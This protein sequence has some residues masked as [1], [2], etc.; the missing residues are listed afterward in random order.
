VDGYAVYLLFSGEAP[1]GAGEVV[2]LPRALVDAAAEQT[3]D[4][5]GAKK[6]AQA[7]TSAIV[8]GEPLPSVERLVDFAGRVAEAAAQTGASAILWAPAERLLSPAMLRQALADEDLLRVAVN[9]RLFHVED[10][11][12]GETVMDTVGLAALGLPDG[13]CHFFELDRGEVAT[14][15][16]ELAR[17]L[18]DEGAVIAEGDTVPGP[19]DETWICH[20][21]EALVD[22]AREVIDLEPPAP[23][24]ARRT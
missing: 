20:L 21:E 3:R 5:P 10:G 9:V 17:Y 14:L 13:Q 8:L 11:A 23:R 16:V 18:A 6:A 2:P 7:A 4:W 22:P 24:S 1:A 15:L 12:P 19:R